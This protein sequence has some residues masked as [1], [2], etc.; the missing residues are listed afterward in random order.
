MSPGK[1]RGIPFFGDVVR[2]KVKHFKKGEIIGKNRFGF[3][4]F[5][6][7][8]VK[9]FNGISGIND[10]ANLIWEFKESGNIGPM[11]DPGI[12]GAGILKSPF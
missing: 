9:G 4:D 12:N 1:G 8:A 2:S 6:K 10:S 5:S 3:G 7:L 11:I